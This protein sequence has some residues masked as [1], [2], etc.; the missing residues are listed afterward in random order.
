[1]SAST[2]K[3]LRKAQEAEKLTEKQLAEQKEAKKLKLY[4][5]IAVV[6][7][8]ALVLFAAIFGISQGI[9]NSGIRERSTVAMTVG[10]HEISN[11][12]HNSICTKREE[13]INHERIHQEAAPESSGS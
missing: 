7:L 3:Q 5:I 1:M 6:V 10:E 13:M 4:S 8:T 11:A 9:A 2:K 12:R